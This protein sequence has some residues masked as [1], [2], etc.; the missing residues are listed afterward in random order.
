MGSGPGGI[1]VANGSRVPS[2]DRAS[3]YPSPRNVSGNVAGMLPR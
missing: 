3:L 2:F 1:W